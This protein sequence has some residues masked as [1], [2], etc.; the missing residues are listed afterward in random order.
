MVNLQRGISLPGGEELF[1]LPLSID[2]LAERFSCCH[3]GY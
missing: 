3:V 2:D 1:L